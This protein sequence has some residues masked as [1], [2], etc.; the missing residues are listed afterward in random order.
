M[1]DY[2][3]ENFAKIYDYRSNE[4]ENWKVMP[5]IHEFSELVFTKLGVTTVYINGRKCMVP[6]NHV[7][8]VLPNQIHEYSAETDSTLRCCVFSNDF[9]PIFFQKMRGYELSDPVVDFSDR[10]ELLKQLEL[11]DKTNTMKICGLMNLICARFFEAAVLRKKTPDNHNLFSDAISFISQNFRKDITLKQVAKDLGY[12][13]KYLSAS[14]HSL[15]KMN[16]R[17]FLVSYR[18]DY[19][20]HLLAYD[21]ENFMRISD[22]AL[23][24]GFSSINS[25]NRCFKEVTG[26]TPSEYRKQEALLNV[27]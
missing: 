14:L 4:H 10:L 20:K 12:N 13:E 27:C 9:I 6:A 3:M 17:E 2:Q 21:K 7:L 8:L 19:A 25:F 1:I 23:E 16:F 11:T 5:H 18:I 24:S 15:T 26:M 22:V